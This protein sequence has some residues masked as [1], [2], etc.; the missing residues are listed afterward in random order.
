MKTRNGTILT[1]YNDVD[2]SW[3]YC[4]GIQTANNVIITPEQLPPDFEK[5]FSNR[6]VLYEIDD[7]YNPIFDENGFAK[8]HKKTMNVRELLSLFGPSK[9]IKQRMNNGQIKFNN[10]PIKSFDVEVDIDFDWETHK[11]VELS[12]FLMDSGMNLNQLLKM[13]RFIGLDILDFFGS[14]TIKE[15][16][17]NIPKFEFLRD[18][19]LVSISKKEHYVFKN[20]DYPHI[21]PY[22]Y[23]TISQETEPGLNNT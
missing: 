15:R 16:P 4:F 10:I 8:L 1:F 17:T 9:E 6:R 19:V 23:E 21:H 13:K 18:Y 2:D 22:S 14:D 7:E 3:D 5:T 12:D 11:L 20:N